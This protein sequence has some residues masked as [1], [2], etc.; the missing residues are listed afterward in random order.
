M[1]RVLL[2]EVEEQR[3]LEAPLLLEAEGA[4]MHRD[5]LDALALHGHGLVEH[6][7]ARALWCVHVAAASYKFV[8]V[9]RM[10]V[11]HRFHPPQPPSCP[12]TEQ[13][14]KHRPRWPLK[15]VPEPA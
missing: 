5:A 8:P 15:V 9:H 13:F 12:Q 4:H 2:G 10:E 3:A 14:A 6:A 1:P 11:L 7:T